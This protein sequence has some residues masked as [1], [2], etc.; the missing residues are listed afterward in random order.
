[1]LVEPQRNT[2]CFVIAANNITGATAVLGCYNMLLG[3]PV[4]PKF[5][6]RTA[7]IRSQLWPGVARVDL[8]L[9]SSRS[10][11]YRGALGYVS[12]LLLPVYSSITV[13]LPATASPDYSCLLLSSATA[14]LVL[15]TAAPGNSR[16]DEH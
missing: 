12:W 16:G 10:R 1:M 14:V 7:V 9:G 4:L 6:R 2:P 15:T 5:D 11:S 8:I 13:V 3:E